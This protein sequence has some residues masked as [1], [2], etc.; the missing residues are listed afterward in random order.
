MTNAVS[1][2]DIKQCYYCANTGTLSKFC[3]ANLTPPPQT[4]R[5]NVFLAAMLHY[6]HVCPSLIHNLTHLKSHC[7]RYL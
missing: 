2:R 1:N 3:V 6:E 5:V 4:I 7:I